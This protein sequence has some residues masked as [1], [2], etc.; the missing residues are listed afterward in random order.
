MRDRLLWTI[1]RL[2][3]VVA[4]LA[5]WEIAAGHDMD[6]AFLLGSPGDC[7]RILYRWCADG[8]F[9]AQLLATFTVLTLGWSIGMVAG[10]AIGIAL[11]S[12]RWWSRVLAPFIGFFNGTP[13]MVFYPFFAVWLG[14]TAASKVVLV[15]FVIIFLII[16]NVVSALGEIDRDVIAHVRVIGGQGGQ[17]AR[18]VY[19][20]ALAG[21]MLGTSRVTVAFALQATLVS[22]FF[23]P[24]QG[25]GHLVLA[26][27]AN[28]DVNQVWAAI[29]VVVVLALILDQ[30]LRTLGARTEKWRSQ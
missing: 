18:H 16:I 13:R 28:F 21:W 14:Y 4:V 10:V 12:S 5:A 30:G 20:P 24:P 1:A 6:V 22:E 11:G 26:G 27:Q 25:V 19:L 23:G 17:L 7:W 15:V 2:V 29:V 9:A 8:T 3:P